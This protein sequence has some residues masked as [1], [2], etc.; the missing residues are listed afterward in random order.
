MKRQFALKPYLNCRSGSRINPGVFTY[1][2]FRAPSEP[3][4]AMKR[5]AHF[6]QRSHPSL[7]RS[8]C[9]VAMV[10]RANV[11]GILSKSIC[12][13][14]VGKQKIRHTKCLKD[15]V[16]NKTVMGDIHI[17]K[18]VQMQTYVYKYTDMHTMGSLMVHAFSLL[19]PEQKAMHFLCV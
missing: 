10:I 4:L 2:R 18:H 14:K 11:W 3:V 19:N 7:G 6:T 1:S 15:R 5:P 13:L 9:L 12:P 16:G 17:H 8:N